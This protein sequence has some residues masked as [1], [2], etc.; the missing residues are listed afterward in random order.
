MLLFLF[1][2][3]LLLFISTLAYGADTTKYNTA[4]KTAA[5]AA[6]KQSGLEADFLKVRDASNKSVNKWVR[7]KGL[8]VPFTVVSF[9]APIVYKKQIRIHTGDFTFKARQNKIT[10]DWQVQF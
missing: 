9:V 3:C 8:Q 4:I 2:W 6:A 10:L 1:M 5:H 7:N